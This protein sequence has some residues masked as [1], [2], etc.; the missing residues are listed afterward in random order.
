MRHGIGY[1]KFQKSTAH[2]RALLRNLATSLILHERIETTLEKAK[3][4]RPVVEKLITSARTDTVTSRRNA[5]GYL[6]DK[7][8]VHKLFTD[9]APRFKTR[10]GGYTRVV[11]TRSRAGDAADMACI[12]L[13]G[14]EESAAATK[15]PA[16]KAKAAK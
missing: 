9:V 16:K 5:Y 15:A 3:E 14:T 11:R 6:M 10:P 8:V 4:L 1:R 12:A 2:T 13:I 7:K